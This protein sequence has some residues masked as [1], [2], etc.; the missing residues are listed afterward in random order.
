MT[1]DFNFKFDFNKKFFPLYSNELWKFNKNQVFS[2]IEFEKLMKKY[3]L[4]LCKK[5]F[6]KE[7]IKKE[8]SLHMCLM[9]LYFD[10]KVLKTKY[11]MFSKLLFISDTN[12]QTIVDIIQY[13]YTSCQKKVLN[14]I[15]WLESVLILIRTNPILHINI[16]DD[17]FLFLL[18]EL[19]MIRNINLHRHFYKTYGTVFKDNIFQGYTI[20]FKRDYNVELKTFSDITYFKQLK[21]L[22]CFKK[23]EYI[24]KDLL[25]NNMEKRN[26]DK[27]NQKILF[28]NRHFIYSWFFKLC[29]YLV[30]S[31]IWTM[32]Q[33]YR[34]I[35]LLWNLF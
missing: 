15:L 19:K 29:L 4:T 13:K 5:I 33:Y 28:K 22:S 27:S 20:L 3:I 35:C 18:K 23:Y 14:G 31:E 12:I 9:I 30:T 8:M 10:T 17:D 34:N 16:H 21:W 7:I 2:E 26:M 6:K 11:K 1:L 32:E 24:V 25:E